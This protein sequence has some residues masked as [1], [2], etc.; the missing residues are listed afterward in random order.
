MNMALNAPTIKK[1]LS[2]KR[3]LFVKKL[4][5][6]CP[7]AEVYL[8]GG[9]VRD[10]FLGRETKDYDFVVRN[11][12]ITRLQKFLQANGKVNLVGKKFGVLKFAPTFLPSQSEPPIMVGGKLRK[13]PRSLERQQK[14]S[15]ST[16]DDMYEPIDIALPRTEFSIG[17]TGHYRDFH[18]QSDS[19]LSIEDDLSRRDFTIN[20]LAWDVKRNV[21]I[22]PFGGQADLKKKIIC[23]VG[24]PAA[25]FQEDY[26]R[27]LRAVR[28]ACS[29]GFTIE[30]ETARAVTRFVKKLNDEIVSEERLAKHCDSNTLR[31]VPYEVIAKE[32]VRAFVANPVR[33]LDLY[34]SFG[35]FKTLAPEFLTMKKCP[36]DPRWHSEGDVWTHTRLALSRLSSPL[37]KREFLEERASPL[38][39]FAVLFHDIGKP[40]TVQI[41]GKDSVDRIRYIGHDRV[42]AD[43][44]RIVERL[45]LASVDGLSIDPET[46]HWLV[47]NHLLIL[48]APIDTMRSNT[49]ERYF[50][51][52][53][54]RGLLL[55]QLMF[56]DG[57]ASLQKNMSPG[58]QAYRRFKK[59][60]AEFERLNVRGAQLPDALLDGEEIM[61]VCRL[62]PSARVGELKTALR[63]EQ[64]AGRIRT[65]SDARKWLMGH[66]N[67][68]LY[69][70]KEFT[71]TEEQKGQR[72]DHLLREL[73]PDVSRSK[74]QKMV[75][76]ELVTVNEKNVTP[77]HFLKAGD[78]VRIN[79]Q[80]KPIEKE[81][82]A[83]PLFRVIFECDEYLVI[84]KPPGLVV[85]GG[86]HTTGRTLVDQL[87]ERYP[88]IRQVGSDPLRPGIVHRLDKEASGVMVIART[89]NSFESLVRQFKLRQVKK[90]YLVLTYGRVEPAVG[91]IDLPITRSRQQYTRRAAGRNEGQHAVTRYSVERFID[92]TSLI[93]VV[94]ETG[95]THQIRVH[96][97][98]K[99]NPI[100]GDP[101][102]VSK[103][104]KKIPSPRLMLHACLLEFL[105]LAG[106]AREYSV[107]P[108]EDFQN[109]LRQIENG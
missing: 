32:M 14:S 54:Y 81:V 26:S 89:Q 101:L 12:S 96:F 92:N 108:N 103:K 95:R 86:A 109:V 107:K 36:H 13:Y 55:R 73:L 8:V 33:A 68:L 25:R 50:Y 66:K 60:L 83:T 100:V 63:E 85:H 46:I 41:P 48:N 31:V 91:V 29:L 40:A 94:P 44:T 62:K 78:I 79:E 19:S 102:Y 30:E 99:G 43:I 28:F 98:S 104:I 24:K 65:K 7:K 57:S 2:Q 4:F 53:P 3:F 58:L 56:I 67:N 69:M 80:E 1:L 64:L 61:K 21:C 22:D 23:A 5:A 27:A 75:K 49:I 17:N 106:E 6:E 18:I 15:L 45:R 71:V 74:L 90:H 37:F 59:K 52:D 39:I 105:D 10:I 34:D 42:G 82:K 87:L 70:K 47:K 38:L 88:E 97:F 9:A 72:L 77:H 16:R 84:D 93:R 35:L 76:D 11:V 51:A 20:A